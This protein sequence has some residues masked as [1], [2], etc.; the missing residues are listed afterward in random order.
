MA[1]AETQVVEQAERRPNGYATQFKPGVSGNPLGREGVARARLE[2]KLVE[3]AADFGGVSALSTLE[4]TL[5]EQ[6]AR[7]LV[8]RLP[9]NPV[10]AVRVVNVVARLIRQVQQGRAPVAA[11]SPPARLADWAAPPNTVDGPGRDDDAD[12]AVDAP[13]ANPSPARP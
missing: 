8:R 6:A 3:L 9:V 7:L 12:G 13:Q 2:A 5:L 11:A 4:R 1:Q 10:D